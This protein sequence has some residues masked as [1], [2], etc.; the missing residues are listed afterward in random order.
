M[1]EWGRRGWG[2]EGNG[3]GKGEGEEGE[4]GGGREKEEE[5]PYRRDHVTDSAADIATDSTAK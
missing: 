1:G 2:G 5:H 3:K 4:G